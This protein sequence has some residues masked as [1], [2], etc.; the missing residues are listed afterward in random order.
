[1]NVEPYHDKHFLSVVELIKSFHEE[2]VKEYDHSIELDALVKTIEAQKKNAFVLTVQDV[3]VGVL[4]GH[5][6]PSMLNS[7][8]IFQETIWYVDE[9]F[10]SNGIKFLNEVKKFLKLRGVN[11]MIMV[12]LENSKSE[13]LKRFYEH[14][15]FKPLERHYVRGI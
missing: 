4:S 6:I 7:G 9:K 12:A 15:G 3:C 1:M 13:K 11:I 5:I 10:R 14:A 2:A 8:L